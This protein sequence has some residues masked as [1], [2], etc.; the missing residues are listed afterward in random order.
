MKYGLIFIFFAILFRIFILEF[1]QVSS[2]DMAPTLLKN[3]YLWVQKWRY[4]I[5]IPGTSV[6]LWRWSAPQRGEV[7][8]MKA[9]HPP[10]PLVFRRVMALPGDRLFYSDGV[11]FI[12]EKM[13]RA[14]TPDLVQKEWDFLRDGDFTGDLQW[15]NY[16]VHWQEE[17]AAGP[18]SILTQKDQNLSFGPYKVPKG[19]YFVMGD[20]RSLAQDSRFW[21][22]NK[23]YAQGQVVFKRKDENS[24]KE[25]IIPQS[26]TLKAIVDPYFPVF[27]T[28]TQSARLT[29]RNVS[30]PVRSKEAG[31]R[32][33]IP[34]GVKWSLEGS[35][36]SVLN[37]YNSSSFS[38]GFD[39]SVVP[40]QSFYG[41][42]FQIVWGCEKTLPV[43]NFLCQFNSSREGRL[44]WSVHK[45]SSK[46]HIK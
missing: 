25:F 33:N 6:Y 46:K 41:R 5:R 29:K 39:Q 7:I 11:L 14:L 16:Y 17:L 13:H 8:L 28:T 10:Y 2:S 27:F 37:V 4:G 12:N 19:H 34:K 21:P 42:A 36:Y 43:L 3:D 23:K 22:S 32:G 45:A 40:F 26:T 24:N 31:F 20:H 44:L 15:R 18:Y 30:V 1:Y 35:L 38:G 9:P